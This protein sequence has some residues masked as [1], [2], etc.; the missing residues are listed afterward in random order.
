VRIEFA[1]RHLEITP[2]LKEFTHKKL[3]KIIK[4]LDDTAEAH[5]TLS[6]EKH[7]QIAEVIIKT[8]SLTLSGSE[9]TDD[10]YASIGL[11]INKIEKQA[12]R[13]R[14]KIWG[15]KRK[16]RNRKQSSLN[17]WS[18]STSEQNPDSN[19]FHIIKSSNFILKPMTVEEAALQI[20][21]SKEYFI[22]F[23]NSKSHK[24]N[25]LYRRKDGYLGLIEPKYD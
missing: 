15:R 18:I 10:M 25:V 20:G 19:G 3:K 21:V 11:A 7:R 9:E 2:A 4:Y 8:K 1:G 16:L 17:E 5:V 22:V 23:Q 24:I 13:L 12:K 6:I 14:Q